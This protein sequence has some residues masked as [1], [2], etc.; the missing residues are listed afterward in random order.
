MGTLLSYDRNFGIIGNTGV[1]KVQR[2]ILD[3][4]AFQ[5]F[6]TGEGVIADAR[7]AVWN[8]DAFQGLAPRESFRADARNAIW[9]CDA[10]QVFATFE[11]PIADARDAV[12]NRD[13]CHG[14]DLN[15]VIVALPLLMLI[16]QT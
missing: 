4:H 6:A 14:S 16:S 13:A 10:F 5:G 3:S 2:R 7:D 12:W 8:R 11:D 15:F 9:N 1:V